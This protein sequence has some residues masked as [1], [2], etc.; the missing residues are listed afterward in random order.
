MEQNKVIFRRKVSMQKECTSINIPSEIARALNLK[1]GDYLKCYIDEGKYGFFLAYWPEKQE[2]QEEGETE[3]EFLK[4]GG[5]NE[6]E[7]KEDLKKELRN[8]KPGEKMYYGT[9]PEKVE[10]LDEKNETK[11]NLRK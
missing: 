9:P 6:E 11:L 10:K 4:E 1:K 3:E 5:L 8:L 2:K 7:E